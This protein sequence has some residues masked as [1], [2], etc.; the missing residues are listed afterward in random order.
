MSHNL[1]SGTDPRILTSS[2]IA[3]GEIEANTLLADF[4]DKYI[5][6]FFNVH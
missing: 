3:M 5:E 2:T 4:Q 6:F 1:H